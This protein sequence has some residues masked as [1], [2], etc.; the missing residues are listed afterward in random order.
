MGNSGR[1]F[2]RRK[3]AATESRYPTLKIITSIIVYA[4]CLCD[5][6]TG[7]ESY[8]FT[9]GRY[10]IFY[11]CKHV[12]AC[13]THEGG[14]GTNESAQELIRRDRNICPLPCP[15]KGSNL[16]SSYLNSDALTTALRPPLRHNKSDNGGSRWHLDYS[17]TSC[18]TKQLSKRNSFQNETAF[19]NML[20]NKGA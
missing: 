16:G 15:T 14:S 10:G 6:T 4:V 7:C 19:K 9:I 2:P 1:G 8:S 3:P 12:G 17:V 13:R 5:H 18:K 20:P 11:V